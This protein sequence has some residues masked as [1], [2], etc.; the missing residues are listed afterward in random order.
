MWKGIFL[1]AEKE[2]SVNKTRDLLIFIIPQLEKFP[3]SQVVSSR[4]QH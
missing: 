1:M 2:N 3:R 4:R